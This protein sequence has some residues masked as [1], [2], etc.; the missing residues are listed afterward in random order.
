MADD[1]DIDLELAAAKAKARQRRASIPEREAQAVGT[2]GQRPGLPA[3][4]RGSDEAM[5]PASV[6]GA[7]TRGFGQG[8]SFGFGDE[9]AASATQG[10]PALVARAFMA[11]ENYDRMMREV[12]GVSDAS[13]KGPGDQ[14]REALGEQR[15]DLAQS[16]RAQPGAFLAGE[17]AGSVVTPGPKVTSLGGRT[18]T[19]VGSR[20]LT[21]AAQGGLVGAG[22]ATQDMTQGDVSGVAG[23][24]LKGAAAGAVMAPLLGAAFDRGGRVLSRWS[25]ENALKALGLR[26]GISNQLDQRGY[27][28]IDEARA[29]GNEALDLGL[30]RFGNKA[31]DVARAASE[32]KPRYGALIEDALASADDAA[33]VLRPG[34]PSFDADRA[35][36]QAAGE[37]MGP[38]GLSPTAIREATRARRLV[39]DITRMD[40]PS[41]GAANRLKSDM[42]AGIKYGNDPALK[43]KLEQRAASGLRKSIEEQMGEV[44]GPEAADQLRMANQRYGS[45][46]DIE[47]LARDEAQRQ[48][49]RKSVTA[50][51]LMAAAAGG[52][53][54]GATAGPG[55]GLAV[56]ALP[57][58]RGTVGPRLPS[59]FAATQ[60]FLSPVAPQ[61]SAP[62]TRA[63]LEATQR[64]VLSEEE[65]VA[66]RAFLNGG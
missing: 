1:I 36:W 38:S 39:D 40:E 45:L 14:Y 46:M 54:V 48:A 17:L 27:S 33:T 58:L 15:V 42:Y 49:G 20:V 57:L 59:S 18:L 28:T 44:A 55:A 52:G 47:G 21:G 3:L 12:F 41:F 66:V 60:R 32:A 64:P 43:T 56:A 24:T 62:S 65:D 34:R 9:L 11:P 31:E 61:L 13:A 22:T 8:G 10:I 25:S 35:A 4:P 23:E 30:V 63:A 6:S 50:L 37:V 53:S 7:L 19:T 51:D 29:L 5:G 16:R 2:L 26:A